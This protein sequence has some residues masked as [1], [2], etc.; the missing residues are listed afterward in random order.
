MSNGGFQSLAV[1]TATLTSHNTVRKLTAELANKLEKML[2]EIKSSGFENKTRKG[3]DCY[4]GRVK[5][6]GKI[7]ACRDLQVVFVWNGID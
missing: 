2:V 3:G 5:K 6:L 4:E 7:A 1:L